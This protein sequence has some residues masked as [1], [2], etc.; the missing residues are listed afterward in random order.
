LSR[1]EE[2][3]ESLTKSIDLDGYEFEPLLWRGIAFQGLGKVDLAVV[4]YKR[5]LGLR[6]GEPR[7]LK[8]LLNCYVV[9]N[10]VDG[11][12]ELLDSRKGDFPQDQ[13]LLQADEM[14]WIERSGHP[15]LLE[16]RDRFLARLESR[17]VYRADRIRKRARQLVDQGRAFDGIQMLRDT[18][19]HDPAFVQNYV[20]LG[21]TLRYWIPVDDVTEATEQE[22]IAA[23]RKATE[24]NP[25]GTAAHDQLSRALATT[26][27]EQLRSP[28]EAVFHAEHLMALKRTEETP[29]GTYVFGTLGMACHRARKFEQAVEALHSARDLPGQHWVPTELFLAMCYWQLGDREQAWKWFDEGLEV[30]GTQPVDLLSIS[31]LAEAR[32]LLSMEPHSPRQAIDPTLSN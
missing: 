13:T 8:P 25:S 15:T 20:L 2:A 22:A 23:F 1:Y 10:D 7:F 17:A 6:P 18:N 29:A 28:E 21:M 11:A 27:L 4:D 12:A 24:L 32:E 26:H 5:G 3:V 31:T 14:A 16:A 30:T 9:L 19:E